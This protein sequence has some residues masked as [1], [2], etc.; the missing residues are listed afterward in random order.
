MIRLNKMTDYA[1]VMLSHMASDDSK[2][3][4]AAQMAQG[5]GVPLPSASKILKQLN[6]A[7]VL[8]SQRGAGGGYSLDRTPDKITVAEIVIALEGPI[9]LTAC[10]DGADT[11]CD[12]MPLCAMSGHWNKVNSAIQVALESVTLADMKPAPFAFEQASDELINKIKSDSQTS[13]NKKETPIARAP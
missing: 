13:D 10:I 2:V 9:A 11:S 4:T 6:K 3:V 5:S 7:N 8:V 12:S 1:V